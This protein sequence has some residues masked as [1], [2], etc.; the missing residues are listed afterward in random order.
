VYAV[1]KFAGN[2]GE[3]RQ[4]RDPARSTTQ[5]YRNHMSQSQERHTYSTARGWQDTRN[6]QCVMQCDTGCCSEL[7]CIAASC[8]VV[9][10]VSEMSVCLVGSVIQRVAACCSVLQRVA[11]IARHACCKTRQLLHPVHSRGILQVHSAEI[12]R[13]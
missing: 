11:R 1:A 2:N 9:Q 12:D 6:Q 5:P 4:Q 10:R 8:S 3:G 7:Q 13:D